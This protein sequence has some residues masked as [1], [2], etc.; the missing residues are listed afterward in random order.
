MMKIFYSIRI[1]SLLAYANAVQ[2]SPILKFSI[3]QCKRK[4]SKRQAI[5]RLY[6]ILTQSLPNGFSLVSLRAVLTPTREIGVKP[7]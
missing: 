4:Q 6:L 2:Y 1:R 7:F 5:L 3:E